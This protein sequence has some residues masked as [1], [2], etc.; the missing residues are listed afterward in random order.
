MGFAGFHVCT[1]LGNGVGT[2]PG[3]PLAALSAPH[4]S[5]SDVPPSPTHVRAVSVSRNADG[6]M[7]AYGAIDVG[8][9][10]ESFL[11]SA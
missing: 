10:V 5:R 8:E 2:A 9:V 7:L 11:V 6:Q 3:Q 4:S 1:A